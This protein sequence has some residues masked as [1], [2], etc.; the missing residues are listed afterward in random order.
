M[1]AIGLART[2]GAAERP[3][4]IRVAVMPWARSNRVVEADPEALPTCRHGVQ[5]NKNRSNARR[6]S[7]PRPPGGEDLRIVWRSRPE[8]FGSKAERV[9]RL[10]GPRHDADVRLGSPGPNPESVGQGPAE[11][12]SL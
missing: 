2:L 9:H 3:G 12:R 1:R 4:Q 5:H 6:R 10:R 7:L 11:K 8:G